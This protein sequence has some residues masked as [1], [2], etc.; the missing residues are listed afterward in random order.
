MAELSLRNVSK[1]FGTVAALLDIDLEIAHREFVVIVG[2][3]G[4][5][6]VD[7]VARH[8]RP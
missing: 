2:A 6:Q 4:L 5:R 8:R 1:T 7:A 3:V